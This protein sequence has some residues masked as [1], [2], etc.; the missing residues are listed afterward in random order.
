MVFVADE[1]TDRLEIAAKNAR[2]VDAA[3]LCFPVRFRYGRQTALW[4]W[5][6]AV[7]FV[8]R[9]SLGIG[10]VPSYHGWPA[11]RL[12]W[13]DAQNGRSVSL[14]RLPDDVTITGAVTLALLDLVQAQE[15]SWPVRPVEAECLIWFTDPATGARE[16]ARLAAL[17]ACAVKVKVSGNFAADAALLRAVSPLFPPGAVRVDANRAY[18][19]EDSALSFCRLLRDLGG[20]WIEE[21]C[22]RPTTWE[23]LRRETG[24]RI[25]GDESLARPQELAAALAVGCL[26][27]VNVK[28]ARLGGP[29]RALR[30]LEELTAAGMSALVGC[31]EDLFTGMAAI[32]HLAACLPAP[33]AEAWGAFR[34]DLTDFDDTV[35][36]FSD[37]YVRDWRSLGSGSADLFDRVFSAQLPYGRRLRHGKSAFLRSAGMQ[38][39]QAGAN[40]GGRL[41]RTLFAREVS[42]PPRALALQSSEKH[43]EK[44]INLQVLSPELGWFVPPVTGGMRYEQIGVAALLQGGKARVL[45]PWGQKRLTA[46]GG[47]QLCVPDRCPVGVSRAA[48]ERAA[49]GRLWAPKG[50]RPALLALYLPL[51]L[52]W[53]IK[54]YQIDV[55]RLHSLSH[56]GVPGILAAYFAAWTGTPVRTVLHVHHVEADGA[57]DTSRPRWRKNLDHRVLERVDRVIVP[58][59]ST[60][61]AL[62]RETGCNESKIFVVPNAVPSVLSALSPRERIHGEEL[63]LLFVGQFIERKRPAIFL[64]LFRKLRARRPCRALMIGAGPCEQVVRAEA[65]AAGVKVRARVPD[66]APCF[67]EADVLVCTSLVE[68]FFLVG[69]EAM[70]RGLPVVAFRVPGV[71]E[72]FLDGQA[73]ALVDQG[74]VHAMLELLAEW[75]DA[76]ARR[77]SAAGLSRAGDFSTEAFT[78][79][80]WAALS[81]GK[82]DTDHS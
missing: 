61:S 28:L 51:Q 20:E 15:E 5:H 37:G 53:D 40:R 25:V 27:G 50:N 10:V 67:D 72:L 35:R 16:A 18:A 55:L 43:S 68:G 56:L 24:I 79:N 70:Q 48:W 2:L 60:R 3:A 44:G 17:G 31:S 54:R 77:W 52:F 71:S 26:D 42:S 57:L 19:D 46:R 8:S 30:L 33:R 1:L 65:L 74:D 38:L 75:D 49:I 64:E 4:S 32:L 76:A 45:L 62:A 81:V 59:F 80:L 9:D 22:A 58:S 12:A 47:E 21:P 63:R 41:A 6:F 36:D 34:L 69:L 82:S 39:V 66:L 29:L 13:A 73:G 78:E 23:R 7:A 11:G 14:D